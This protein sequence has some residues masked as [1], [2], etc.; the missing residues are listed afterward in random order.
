MS[1]STPAP[2]ADGA[3]SVAEV[4]AEVSARRTSAASSSTSRTSRTA[5]SSA[6]SSRGGASAPRRVTVAALSTSKCPAFQT[7]ARPAGRA[8][9]ARRAFWSFGTSSTRDCVE[10][11][12]NPITSRARCVLPRGRGDVGREWR[13]WGRCRGRPTRRVCT[14][15]SEPEV[16]AAVRARSLSVSSCCD[17]HRGGARG[18]ASHRGLRGRARQVQLHADFPIRGPSSPRGSATV[19]ARRHRRH[20][21]V[22]RRSPRRRAGA[23]MATRIPESPASGCRFAA[24][25]PLHDIREVP[26]RRV[27]RLQR[28]DSPGWHVAVIS[29]SPE[30]SSAL[31][32]TPPARSGPSSNL[33]SD[34]WRPT[35]ASRVSACS[36]PDAVHARR[37]PPATHPERAGRRVGRG[38][39][40]DAHHPIWLTA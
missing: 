18:G 35:T 38:D 30:G 7:R 34:R 2:E 13:A 33:R 23:V 24:W 32:P 20:P 31:L 9:G 16:A 17:R 4:A 10:S 19:R 39:A 29:A 12:H 1:V 40:M 15:Y 22:P 25:R 8:S 21:R 5:K 27:H 28:R 26:R 6:M 37:L 36:P 11:P 14:D 3:G